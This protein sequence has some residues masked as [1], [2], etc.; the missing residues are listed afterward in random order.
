MKRLAL[1]DFAQKQVTKEQKTDQLL[2][3][4]LG[5]CHDEV[6]QKFDKANGGVSNEVDF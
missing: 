2:G 6:Q 4:V 3:K 5:I 1:K